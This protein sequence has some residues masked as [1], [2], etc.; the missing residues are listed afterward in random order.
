MTL[1]KK[2]LIILCILLGVITVILVGIILYFNLKPSTGNPNCKLRVVI[3]LS[4][5]HF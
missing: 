3:R 5:K 4:I 2:Q 1:S